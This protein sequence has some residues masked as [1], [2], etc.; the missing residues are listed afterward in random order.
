MVDDLHGNLAGVRSLEGAAL[1]SVKLLPGV[2][3]DFSFES[4]G[5]LFI[6]TVCAG[7]VGVAHEEALIIVVD[8]LA[9][10]PR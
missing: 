5:E 6:G 2:D 7:E 10:G 9:Y 4:F 1:C 3:V 8:P